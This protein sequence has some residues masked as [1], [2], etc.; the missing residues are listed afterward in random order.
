MEYS[1]TAVSPRGELPV[2]VYKM[3]ATRC[4]PAPP[5][6]AIA[7]ATRVATRCAPAPPGLAIATGGNLDFC[8]CV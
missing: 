8:S 1:R 5:G 7:T 2:V 6:L 4:A 3:V